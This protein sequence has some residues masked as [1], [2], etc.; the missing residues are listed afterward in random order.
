LDYI[1]SAKIFNK[2]NRAG[3]AYATLA[4]IYARFADIYATVARMRP[5]LHSIL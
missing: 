5:F 3:N 4:R 2:N 1:R